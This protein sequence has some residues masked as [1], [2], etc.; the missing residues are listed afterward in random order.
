MEDRKRGLELSHF[1]RRSKDPLLL[2]RGGVGFPRQRGSE[3]DREA[4]VACPCSKAIE[5]WVAPLSV[6]VLRSASGSDVRRMYK[7][8]SNS[9]LAGLV[10]QHEA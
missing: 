8:L 1:G 4:A 3:W 6:R 9:S 10:R 7:A 5:G 2:A